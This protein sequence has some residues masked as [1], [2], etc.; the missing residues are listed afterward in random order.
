MKNSERTAVLEA[1][2]SG[3]PLLRRLRE[4]LPELRDRYHV[5]DLAVFGSR[6]RA[7]ATAKSDLDLLVTFDQEAS[8]FDLVGM[9]LDLEARFGVHVD[10]VTPDSIKPRIR[11][12]ILEDA[13]PV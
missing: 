13:V 5:V 8:L 6:A 4:L 2:V 11:D 7:D 10:V 9:E 3:E 12:G 1:A